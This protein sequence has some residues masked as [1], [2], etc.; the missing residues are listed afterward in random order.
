MRRS[1]VKTLVIVLMFVILVSVQFFAYE[2]AVTI[3][4]EPVYFAG[5]GPTIIDDRTMVP[6]RGVFE[7]LG[8]YVEWNGETQT[9]TLADNNFEIIITIDSNTF[10]TNGIE[11]ELDVPA[12]IIYGRTLLPIRAVLESVGFEVGWDGGTNTVTISSLPIII[13]FSDFFDEYEDEIPEP[14]SA[15]T[16]MEL[17]DRQLTYAER[18]EWIENYIAMGGPFEFELQLVLLVNEIRT[19]NNLSEV[20][21]DDTLMKAARFY[22]QTMSDLDTGLGHNM[23]PYATFDDAHGASKAIAETFGARLNIWNGGNAGQGYHTPQSQL[24]DWMGSSGHEAFI[25]SEEHRYIGVGRFGLFTYLHLTELSSQPTYLVEA[26]R[27]VST[28]TPGPTP[29]PTPIPTL[30]SYSRSPAIDASDFEIAVFELVN[31]ERQRHGV[32]PVE[33]NNALAE[34]ARAHSEDLAR[35]NLMGHVSSDGSTLRER[36]ARTRVVNIGATENVGAG[37]T[38]PEAAMMIWMRSPGHRDNMLRADLTHVGIGFYHLP[39]S[40]WEFY[41]TQKFIVAP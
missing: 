33:W 20:I 38:T 7:E 32:P 13:P 31:A 39:G 12:Q 30:T 25:L 41:V 17:P 1:A 26:P 37:S 24:D 18:Q 16:A 19:E 3:D 29:S 28:L 36:I 27:P 2:I 34:A 8:F 10:T 21:I 11:H 35:N 40:Q 22:A 5:Q 9:V 14:T 4:G 6:V 23:G 15:I